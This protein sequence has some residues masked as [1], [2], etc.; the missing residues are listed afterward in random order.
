MAAPDLAQELQRLSRLIHKGRERG[1][2]KICTT[3]DRVI[4]ARDITLAQKAPGGQ[5]FRYAPNGWSS[6]KSL[7]LKEVSHVEYLEVNDA[8]EPR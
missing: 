3:N 5:Y 7:W 2:I 6:W 4:W 1:R 8:A